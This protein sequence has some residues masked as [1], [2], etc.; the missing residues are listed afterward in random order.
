MAECK[1]KRA[2]IKRATLGQGDVATRQPEITNLSSLVDAEA[3]SVAGF[4]PI[5]EQFKANRDTKII[6]A[7]DAAK[8][9]AMGEQK[10]L[11]AK[12]ARV[13]HAGTDDLIR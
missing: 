8:A 1:R 13:A 6:P 7:F 2:L 5:W 11:Y 9:Q 12:P 4:K 10:D 3:D